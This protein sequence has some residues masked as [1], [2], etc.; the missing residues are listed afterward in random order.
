MKSN[1]RVSISSCTTC[2]GSRVGTTGYENKPGRGTEIRPK[3]KTK[4]KKKHLRIYSKIF[5]LKKLIS[6]IFLQEKKV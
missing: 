4:T 6:T 2:S 1:I 3:K 5:L